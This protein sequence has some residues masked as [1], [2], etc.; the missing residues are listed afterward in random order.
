MASGA[1]PPSCDNGRFEDV[2]AYEKLVL[3]YSM[4]S[5]GHR[6]IIHVYI[7]ILARCYY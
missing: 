4:Y 5:A 7:E 1:S 2:G 6:H 3:Q